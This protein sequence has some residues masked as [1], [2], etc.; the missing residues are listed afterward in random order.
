M[1]EKNENILLEIKNLSVILEKSDKTSKVILDGINLTLNK[2]QRS[3]LIGQSGSGKTITSRAILGL[4]PENMKISSG[5]I[6]FD[7]Q[8][9]SYKNEADLEN[10]RGKK[11][12]MIFQEP[13]AA[14]NPVFRVGTQITDVLKLNLNLNKQTAAEQAMD[15]L[16][17]VGFSNPQEI[18]KMYP[19]QLSGGMAQRVL[20]AM[21]LSCQPELIIA[22]EPTSALDAITQSKILKLIFDLQEKFQFAFLI[23]SH[24]IPLVKKYVAD[25]YILKDGEIVYSGAIKKIT[26]P[27]PDPYIQSLFETLPDVL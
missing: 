4:L 22:D 14:L 13:H 12:A 19:G 23:I 26:Y 25:V 20:I 3:A 18:Y 10:L 9:I 11:I 15:V 2:K 27:N 16:S 24:D 5:D 6:R 1:T 8:I 17:Q 21:A 7:Q